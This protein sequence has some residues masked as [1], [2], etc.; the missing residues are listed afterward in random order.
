[1]KDSYQQAASQLT[2]DLSTRGII[3]L[4]TIMLLVWVNQTL[5][6]F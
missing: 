1:M 3:S 4:S 5:P 6:P 2:S